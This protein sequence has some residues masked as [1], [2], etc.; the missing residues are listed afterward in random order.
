MNDLNKE[1]L[2]YFPRKISTLISDK[3]DVAEEIRIR[4]AKNILIKTSNKFIET[5]YLVSSNDILEILQKIC[6]YSIY[7][8]QNQISEGYIT[9]KGG[10]RIGITGTC[11]IQDEK[12]VNIKYVNSLNFRIARQIIGAAINIIPEILNGNTI[13]NTII[14]SPPGYGKTTILKDVIRNLSSNIFNVGVVDERGEI[15]AMFKGVP[16]NDLGEKIDVIENVP[17]NIGIKMLIRSMAPQIVVADEIG[18]KE[19]VD[20]INYAFCSGVKGIFT[21]HGADYEDFIKNPYMKEII[22]LNIIDKLIFL[23]SEKGKIENVIFLGESKKCL[24]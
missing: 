19:D 24:L 12:V 13:W 8:Y 16:Q 15:S 11:V 21:C 17:K 18:T 6:E 9:V 5:N 4:Q 14:V 10:H 23:S 3:I 20:A 2:E 1:V 7:S 22:K